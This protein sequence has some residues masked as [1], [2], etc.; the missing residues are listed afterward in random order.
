MQIL[1]LF[2]LNF[3][4]KRFSVC[5]SSRQNQV[6]GWPPV[7]NF[8]KNQQPSRPASQD[9]Q[10]RSSGSTTP[11]AT[12]TT[13]TTTSVTPP[14]APANSGGTPSQTSSLLVKVYMD[15]L[16]IGRKVDLVVN[17][18]YDKLKS[19]LEDLFQQFIGTATC[20]FTSLYLFLSYH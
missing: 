1:S 16:P 13:N 2:C 6:V 5:A 20:P 11:Q 19:A 8:R 4:S 15:G 12:T 10:P 18:S 14:K 7:R 9:R 17:N 3:L